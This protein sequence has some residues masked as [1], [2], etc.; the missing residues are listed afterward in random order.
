MVCTAHRADLAN[1][2]YTLVAENSDGTV[3]ASEAITV[4][5]IYSNVSW[6]RGVSGDFAAAHPMITTFFSCEERAGS[7][8]GGIK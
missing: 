6:A 3:V 1:G 4:N 7:G 2:P 8:T 5:E